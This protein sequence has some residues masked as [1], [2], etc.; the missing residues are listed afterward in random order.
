M[1]QGPA[2][3]LEE[4]EEDISYWEERW[5]GLF[6]DLDEIQPFLTNEVARMAR[7]FQA[8]NPQFVEILV[9]DAEGRLAGATGRVEDYWQ[10]DESWWQSAMHVR[11]HQPW[12]EG[13]EYDDS[14]GVYSIDVAVVLFEPGQPQLPIGVMKG[15][16]EATPILGSLKPLLG[17]DQPISQVILGNDQAD[18]DDNG[19]ILAPLFE[20]GGAPREP[21]R[22]GGTW[23]AGRDG[24][25]Y[26][27]RRTTAYNAHKIG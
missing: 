12:I 8:V 19:R 26:D 9:T 25:G 16:L 5:P 17:Q 4:L 2:P 13:I 20:H 24:Q 1:N 6:E 27:L 11:G 22:R 14:A 18:P 3:G 7:A 23:R 10:A 15:V 21:V